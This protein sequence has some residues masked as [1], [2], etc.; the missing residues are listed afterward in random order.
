MLRRLSL[1]VI[2]VMLTA[3]ITP[4]VTAEQA[5]S[6]TAART[7][8]DKSLRGGRY[9]EVDT[10]AQ[11]FPKDELIA[12]SHALSVVARGDYARAEAILQPLAAATPGGEAAL[13]LGLLQIGIGKRVEGRRTL[14]LVLMAE[15]PKPG[16]RDYLRLARASRALNRVDDAQ[17]FFR[18]AIGLAPADPR[19]NTEWGLLFLEKYN[20]AEASKSFQEALKTDPD[21]GPALVGM[22]QA[23]EDENPPQAVQFAQRALKINPSDAGAQ[24][25]LAQVAVYSD[26]KAEVKAAIESVLAVNP[27]HL[28]ALS[29]KAA[30]AYVEGR[31]QHYQESVAAALKIN[32]TYGEIHRIVGSMT[33]HYYRFDEAVEHTRKA[34]ALDKENV[35]AVADLGQQLMRTGDERNARRNLETAFRIDKWDVQTYNLL[36]LLDN[37]EPFDTINE[38]TMVIRLAPDESPVLKYYVPMLA[39][40]ALDT[41]SKRWD[42]TPKGPILVE[43]FPRHDD[44]A[45]RTLGLPGMLGALGACFGRVVTL[46]SPTAREPGTFNWGETLWHE[47]AHVITLQLS[48]N[49]L[50]RWLSEG[51]S[52]FEERRARQDWGRDMD[53]P[54]ARAIDRGQV[55]KIKD[56]N[57]GFSSSQTI[58]FAY[59]QAS[60]VVEHIFTTYGQAKLRALIAAYADGSDTE[61]AIKKALGIDIDELQKGFDASLETRYATLRRALKAPAELTPEMSL[62]KV[63][64]VA[65]AHPES[66]PA[67]MALGE[68]LAAASP[69]AAIAAFEKA[70]ELIPNVPGEDSPQ[71]AIAAI[72]LKKG[73]KARAARALESLISY[74]HTDVVSARQ[75]VSLLDAKEPA[76]M[77]AALKRVVSVDPFDGQAHGVLGRMALSAGDTAEAVRLFRVALAA[78]PLDKAGAHADLAE[79]LLKSGQRDEARRHVMEALLIAPTFSRAQDLLLKL[80]EGS[81]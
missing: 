74:S 65:S 76:T 60:L 50:P 4:R 15:S 29:M 10:V 75:L 67:Q 62:D 21:Y 3:G 13:E 63:K 48:G 51:T 44:F 11:A 16:A 61:E 72:A 41:L 2:L 55:I 37:L 39:R 42:F 46:D 27:N 45:V 70:A 80:S 54:F 18:D 52:V 33:A 17:S 81:R 1:L 58:N 25:V 43:M 14:T 31:D 53:L 8:A 30:M 19:V 7:T 79:A 66:F 26:K 64:A 22:A 34:I 49:R 12:V 57:S 36:E 6:V 24:L 20:K 68:A 38:G 71:A 59:Y 40:E 23:L 78:K 5:Q 35:R 77:Q 32:P 47:L 69:D 56:L 28:E 73:D 9:A